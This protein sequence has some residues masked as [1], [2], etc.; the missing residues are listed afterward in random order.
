M[1]GRSRQETRRSV[2]ATI[3]SEDARRKREETSRSLRQTKKDEVMLKRRHFTAELIEETTTSNTV[4]TLEELPM[5]LDAA[6]S[7]NP[8]RKLQGTRQI[9]KLLSIERQPPIDEVIATGIVPTLV[10]YLTPNFHPDLQFEAAWALTNIASGTAKHTLTVLESGALPHLIALM[11]PHSTEELKEQAIWAVGNIA[12]DSPGCRDLCINLNAIPS[13]LSTLE[14]TTRISLL[15]NA[16][17]TLSNLCRGKPEPDFSKVQLCLPALAK[18][19]SYTDEEILTDSC[20]ALSYLS[21]GSNNKIQAVIDTGVVPRIAQLLGHTAVSVVTP[22]LRTIGN[23]VT[24]DDSQTQHVI[25]SGALRYLT[26]LL[27][28]NKRAIQK[29]TC[30]LISNITAGTPAQIQAVIDSGVMPQIISLLEEGHLDV[31]RE[32]AWALSNATCAGTIEQIHFLV[33]LGALK[34]ICNLLESSDSRI[35]NV[36]LDALDNILKSGRSWATARSVANKGIEE[37]N[38]YCEMVEELEGLDKTRITPNT[39]SRRDL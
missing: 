29:E 17:W 9:R 14:G 12:G 39:S 5:I 6:Q 8:Q 37:N 19:L 35:I 7:D 24:G 32:A 28:N 1:S 11:G 34:P 3:S 22:S 26:S 30:W 18:L 33:S 20:W 10:T 15:R 27:K 23:I 31:K 13:I 4:P 38:P 25:S 21:D 36:L 16:T 2:K